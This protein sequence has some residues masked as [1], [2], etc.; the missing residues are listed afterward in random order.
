MGVWVGEE[1]LDYRQGKLLFT[2]FGLSGPLILN[3]ATELSRLRSRTAR[4]GDLVL[5]IDF[6]PAVEPQA[7]DREL[8]SLFVA[9]AG[10]KLKNAL[11]TFLPPRLTSRLLGASSIDPEKSVAQVTRAER[12]VLTATL[13]GF[14]LTFKKLMDE[15]RAVVSSGGLH[16]D[17]I[18]W[19][20]MTCKRFPNLSVTGDLLDINR[21]SGGFSLQLCWA[22]GRVA[23]EGP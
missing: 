12:E 15:S 6:F 17:E 1:R 8:V 2:H 14:P 22:T 11:G 9:K 21:P 18:D 19:R 23:G 10:K 4:K 16:I 5:R 13:K 20:T 7:L 3:F